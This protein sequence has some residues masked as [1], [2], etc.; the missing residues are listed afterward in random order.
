MRFTKDAFLN[1]AL[2]EVELAAQRTGRKLKGFIEN[3]TSPVPQLLIF[4]EF[5]GKGPLLMFLVSDD[6]FIPL[7]SFGSLL[8][9]DVQRPFGLRKIFP[10]ITALPRQPDDEFVPIDYGDV[11]QSLRFFWCRYLKL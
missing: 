1:R 3:K 2:H 7:K 6:G 9:L 11:V 8:P 5:I 10:L 4:D